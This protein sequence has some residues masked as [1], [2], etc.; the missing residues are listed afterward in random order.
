MGD[1]REMLNPRTVAVIG[2]SEE[3]GSVG[4][5]L[6]ENLIASPD[7]KVFPVNPNRSTLL[8][9]NCYPHVTE[10]AVHV[11]LAVIATPADLVPGVVEECGEA[12]VSG[13]LIISAGF[14]ES[15]DEG[16]R[17]EDA[18]EETRKR[19]GMRIMGPNCIGFMRPT[20]GLNATVLRLKPRAG[21][22]AF[23]SQS[24]ALGDAMA[25]WGTSAS[26]GFS[27]I[28]SLGSM[29]DVTYGD[30]IDF[31]GNDLDTRSIMIS[32]EQVVDAR[33]FMSAARGFARTK[34]IVVLK[35]GRTEKSMEVAASHLGDRVSSDR[36]YDA[37]FRR[38]GVVRVKEVA[39]LFNLAQVLDSRHLP[40]G[41]R[42]AVVT[43]AASVGIIATDTLVELQGQLAHLGHESMDALNAILPANWSRTNPVD[44]LGGADVGRYLGAAKVVLADPGVDGLLITHT[45]RASAD[46]QELARAVVELAKKNAKPILGVWMGGKEG[47]AGRD[48]LSRNNVPA[49]ATPEEAVRTYLYMYHYQRNIELL[50]QAPADVPAGKARL[51]NFLR[52]MARNRTKEGFGSLSTLEA[53]TFLSNYGLPVIKAQTAQFPE[54]AARKAELLGYPVMVRQL[55]PDLSGFVGATIRACSNDDMKKCFEGIEPAPEKD[56]RGRPEFLLQK[57]VESE[58]WFFTV[59]A[60]RDR[61]FGA[62]LV[63]GLRKRNDPWIERTAIGLPPLNQTLAR[64]LIEDGAM[65]AAFRE[66]GAEASK[67]FD[68]LETMLVNFSNLVVDFPEI[69]S[70]ILDPVVIVEDRL[71]VHHVSCRLDGNH[72]DATPPYHHLTITPYPTRYVT[73]WNL[74]DGTP[75]IFRPIKPEDEPLGDEMIR[76]LSE[77]TIRARFFGKPLI[78]HEMHARMCNIDYDREIAIVV[79]ITV[80]GKKRLIGAGRIV[81]ETDSNSGQFSILV[82]DD[83][84]GKGLGEKLTDIVIG[85]AQEK[86]LVR[87]Y[88]T[89]LTENDRMIA[90]ARKLGF[91]TQSMPGGVTRIVLNLP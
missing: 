56:G 30:L 90:V 71:F 75:V 78:S 7:R 80:D 85:I 59:A 49:Y 91:K 14:R 81:V 52:V 1:I 50:Y 53:I 15:G 45:S 12:G 84:Q 39:D 40:K 48:I 74:S 73:P 32:M 34:P 25:D 9:L 68:Q 66:K 77:E 18:I 61:E 47:E 27:L 26:I 31:L 13:L 17:R 57:I 41:P 46:P 63:L 10:I 51:T 64:R 79:E 33:K 36:A 3:E 72:S 87:I 62:L 65:E 2:A 20:V 69:E 58:D 37:M 35:P 21:N 44:I 89:V 38:V 11:D 8:G 82:H 24:G 55:A 28:A 29:I 76:S 86:G 16:R 60:R 5:T 70:M 23:I 6:L 19:Y 22:I 83:Y 42:L 88:G 43:N 67:I 54:E 4:R